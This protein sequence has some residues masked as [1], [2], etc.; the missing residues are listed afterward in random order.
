MSQRDLVLFGIGAL[1]LYLAVKKKDAPVILQPVKLIGKPV[2][3]LPYEPREKPGA[4]IMV[5]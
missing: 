3:T 1:A 4:I 5:A 2:I